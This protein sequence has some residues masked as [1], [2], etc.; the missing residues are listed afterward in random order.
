MLID[1]ITEVLEELEECK[2]KF[3]E[4]EF[5]GK[6]YILLQQVYAENSARVKNCVEYRASAVG[7][8]WN[9]YT[10]V[11]DLSDEYLDSARL[12][13]L[14]QRYDVSS[15]QEMVDEADYATVDP[16]FLEDLEEIKELEE[17]GVKAAYSEEAENACTWDVI[18][19]VT[20]Q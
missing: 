8:D 13:K 16:E 20:K 7:E 11:W 4:V 9:I 2:D 17:N 19:S 10:V 18:V 6:K 12:S 5:E 3:G 1:R 14:Y 15:S